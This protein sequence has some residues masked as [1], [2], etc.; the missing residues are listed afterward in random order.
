MASVLIRRFRAIPFRALRGTVT[1]G[2]RPLRTA[3]FRGWGALE[4]TPALRG[5][6]ALSASREGWANPAARTL[7]LGLGAARAAGADGRSLVLRSPRP[8]AEG[9]NACLAWTAPPGSPPTLPG[10]APG[11]EG[12]RPARSLRSSLPAAAVCG[13]R[14]AETG[15]PLGPSTRLGL[16]TPSPA[17]RLLSPAGRLGLI[18]GGLPAAVNLLCPR[19]WTAAAWGADV[20]V[21]A[22]GSSPRRSRLSGEG[23][24]H[25]EAEECDD[26][27]GLHS[28][29]GV[30]CF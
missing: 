22:A 6:P 19:G 3:G 9:A 27:F 30:S 8:T 21:F 25:A 23:Q 1:L 16:G 20:I 17:R 13:P 15:L 29:D 11:L 4:T 26:G 28:T 14:L 12:L 2:G 10:A 5:L 18:L 24:S 7:R